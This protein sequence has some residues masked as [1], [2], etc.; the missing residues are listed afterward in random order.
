MCV[1]VCMCVLGDCQVCV[2]CW[3]VYTPFLTRQL[4]CS[5]C[6]K[7]TGMSCWPLPIAGGALPHVP[8]TREH[9]S[10]IC[11]LPTWDLPR[12]LCP[13]CGPGPHTAASPLEAQWGPDPLGQGS[14]C[15]AISL[16]WVAGLVEFF[17]FHQQRATSKTHTSDPSR[18]FAGGSASEVECGHLG[19][20]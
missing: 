20:P 5:L 7:Q 3:S 17:Q 4:T 8:G 13:S 2:V 10:A 6:V 9:V 16:L 14:P 12:R 19:S 1:G 18:P 15:T 11:F